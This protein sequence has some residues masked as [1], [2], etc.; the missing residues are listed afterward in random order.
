MEQSAGCT[1]DA[2]EK[3]LNLFDLV[4]LADE[5]LSVIGPC[6]GDDAPDNVPFWRGGPSVGD[7]NIPEFLDR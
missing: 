5:A 7:D 6:V 3:I 2:A 1:A 4:E